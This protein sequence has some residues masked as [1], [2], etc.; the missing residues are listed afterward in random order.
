M[1]KDMACERGVEHS[2]HPRLREYA[3]K[4]KNSPLTISGDSGTESGNPTLFNFKDYR[5]IRGKSPTER[6][7]MRTILRSE[8][9]RASSATNSIFPG[10]RPTKK[11]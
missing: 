11:I 4:E 7:L 9:A 2:L 10:T 5:R 6:I 1:E 3:S 8:R